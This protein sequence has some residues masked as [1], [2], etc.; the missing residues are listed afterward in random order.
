MLH[1]CDFVSQHRYVKNTFLLLPFVRNKYT[2][3]HLCNQDD[4]M[5]V[6]NASAESFRRRSFKTFIILSHMQMLIF[7]SSSGNKG[8]S[9]P[10]K[11][12]E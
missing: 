11:Y 1:F 8:G 4:E 10:A 2:Q 3:V 7:L 6:G 12:V 9:H 5:R